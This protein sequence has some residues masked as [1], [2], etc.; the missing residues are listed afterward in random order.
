M[1]RLPRFFVVS[2]ASALMA[3][4]SLSGA[5]GEKKVVDP[6]LAPIDDVA[7]LPRVLLLGDSIS[8]GYTLPV[9]EALKGKANVHRP[10]TNCSSTG[11]A[12]NHLDSW[13]G[14]GKWDVIHFNFGLHDA[15]LPPEGVRHAPPAVYEKNLRE[16][17][18][19]LQATGAALIWATTTPVPN[20]GFISPTRRF[21][22]IDEYNAIARKVM[23]ES[24]VA[25]DDLNAAITPHL[26]TMQRPNDVHYTSE[27]S[28]I[29][30]QEVVASVEAAL[31]VRGDAAVAW[32]ARNPSGEVVRMAVAAPADPR[33]AHLSWNKVVR[34]AKGTIVLACVAGTFHGS[35]G[36]GCP[37]VVRSSDGGATFSDLRI[38]REFGPGLDYTCCG[39]LALGIGEDGAIVLLAMA[40][41]GDEANH[42]FGWRSEDEGLTW[43]PTDTGKFG[44]NRTGSVFGNVFPLKGEGLVVFGHFRVGS[45]PHAEGIWM[46]ASKD[47][48]RSW[49]EAR[50]IADVPAVEPVVIHS[51]D[52]LIGFFR[53]TKKA[54]FDEPS[55]E[56]RQFLGV[57]TD[58]G[59]TWDTTLS[60]LDAE[61]PA[62]AKLAAPCAVEDPERP[63][64]LLVLTTERSDGPGQ[65]SRIWLWKGKADGLEWR[66]ER[67]VLEFPPGGPDNPNT[68]LGYPWMLHQG[69]N[70]WSVYFYHGLKKGASSIWVTEFGI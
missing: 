31:A 26:A 39:N 27:G 69:G 52:K 13:L 10:P 29:L 34:T 65:N 48:G 41:T 35:H 66:R 58:Q 46:A 68:D 8:I 50:L 67:V 15:K 6:A 14:K 43:K 9:R 53:S 28:A 38:L 61:N 56:G 54:V 7:G 44:P 20:G 40:Y 3:A 59:W 4:S 1:K 5:D 16:V 64:E 70:R 24:G 42:V 30:A 12:L 2:M 51:Q 60:G 22:N 23:E 62:T 21:G 63:G 45:A 37:A 55:A 36:G 25:I 32:Q 47:H 11:N 17:V 19:R 49:G 18:K 57:S 33:F